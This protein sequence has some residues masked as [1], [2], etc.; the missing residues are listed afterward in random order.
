MA[1]IIGDM[2]SVGCT[3]RGVSQFVR[4]A[5]WSQPE[6]V[7]EDFALVLVRRGILPVRVDDV[8]LRVG[9][10]DLMLVPPQGR[11]CGTQYVTDPLE[12]F[13]VH[14]DLA[15]WRRSS[16]GVNAS[17]GDESDTHFALP[18]YGC[19]VATDR[20]TVMFNQLHDIHASH[21]EGAASPYC[22]CFIMAMLM[23]LAYQAGRKGGGEQ[24]D[25]VVLQRV[26]DW[27]KA[28]AFDDISVA[29]IAEQFNYSA[30]WLST[31][32]KQEFGVGIAAQ[33]ANIRIKRAEEL[34]MSTSMSV[35]QV[36]Q[37]TGFNDAK[38]FMRV[39]KQHTGLTPTRYRTSFPL[40]HYRA[41]R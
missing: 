27:I 29:D 36:A 41:G 26:N 9:P 24:F 39:F 33:I 38:Y 22:D 4:M 37:A 1:T 7:C 19:D 25:H 5:G 23:E 11:V 35:A 10:G 28:N 30:G 31:V 32:Y 14:F 18:L 34:L 13:S 6:L 12:Y 2:P 3:C 21:G 20:L 17:R 16:L 8:D 15:S 40:R